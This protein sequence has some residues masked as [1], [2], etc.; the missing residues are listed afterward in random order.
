[1]QLTARSEAMR[2]VSTR[3]AVL[4]RIT[5]AADVASPTK[6]SSRRKSKLRPH[7]PAPASPA[8]SAPPGESS[9]VRPRSGR[10]RR[11]KKSDGDEA[12]KAGGGGDG[13]GGAD[14]DDADVQPN[15]DA[16][17]QTT[18]ADPATTTSNESG[19]NTERSEREADE[20]ADVINGMKN[21]MLNEVDR[22]H[23]GVDMMRESLA[24]L[25]EA[26]DVSL[27]L[28]RLSK[29][30]PEHAAMAEL[31]PSYNVPAAHDVEDADDVVAL[32]SAV[33][34]ELTDAA[35]LLSQLT[36]SLMVADIFGLLSLAKILRNLMTRFVEQ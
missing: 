20:A 30:R 13:G 21:E 28:L 1:V 25:T 31:A 32:K 8:P 24:K 2:G 10:R 29:L 17:S 33:E 23:V 9:P 22:V 35:L 11:S 26:S 3:R 27:L 34:L 5:S 16:S 19:A 36:R 18:T 14:D 12:N 4:N 15:A 6:A 7:A